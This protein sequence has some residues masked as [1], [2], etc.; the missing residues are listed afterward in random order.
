M[1]HPG[2]V[3]RCTQ[4]TVPEFVAW[5]IWYD[6]QIFGEY[7]AWSCTTD[8]EMASLFATE[9]AALEIARLMDNANRGIKMRCEVRELGEQ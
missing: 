5:V 6:K 9:V 4:A 1:T 3:V 8:R 7:V 2:Y